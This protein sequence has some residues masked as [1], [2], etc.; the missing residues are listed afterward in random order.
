MTSAR[1]AR[2]PSPPVSRSTQLRGKD[3]DLEALFF[4]L[5]EAPENVNRNLT[6]TEGVAVTGGA[7]RA[8][9][10]KIFTTRLWWGMLFGVVLI[11]GGVSAL[12]ASL[13]G[14]TK[15]APTRPTTRS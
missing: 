10:R 11:G 5:T 1:S 7:V 3:A 12:F 2:S 6:T 14:T 8:E 4:E 9:V 15:P 13:V